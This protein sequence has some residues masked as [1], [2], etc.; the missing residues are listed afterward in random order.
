MIQN[1]KYWILSFVLLI[2]SCLLARHYFLSYRLYPLVYQRII[3]Y[4]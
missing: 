4:G 1:K 3:V 2:L